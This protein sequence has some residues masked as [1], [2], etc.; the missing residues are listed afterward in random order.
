MLS[1]RGSNRS[2]ALAI[3]LGLAG[4]GAGIVAGFLAGASP[5][6]LGLAVVAVGIVWY[7]F[8]K[9][10]QAVLGLLIL[11]S[12]LDVFSDLQIPA[13]FAVGLDALALLYVIVS[14]LTGRIIRTD[15][16]WWFLV[17]WVLLQGLWL[18]LLHLG[19]LGLDASY[20]LTS[21]REWVRLFSWV[22]VYLLVMQLK[23]RLPPEKVISRLFLALPL[24]IAVA[25]L[26]IPQGSDRIVGTFGTAN[27]FATFLLLFISLVWWNLY[28]TQQQ[29]FW[30]MLLGLL[31]FF[32]VSTKSLFSLMMIAVFVLVL[33]TPRLNVAKL[34]SGVLLLGLVIALFASTEFGQQRLASIAQTPLLNP[35]MDISRAI[36]LSQGDSN[37]FN[38]RLSQWNLLLNAWKQSPIFGYG[39]GLSI[40]VAGNDLLPHNDYIRALVEGGIIGLITFLALFAA[41]FIHLLRLIQQT[42]YESKQRNLCFILLAML[43]S[44]PVGMITENIWSHTTFFFYWWVLLAVASWNWN[45]QQIREDITFK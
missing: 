35:D 20:L 10:E 36:L 13:A 34:I 3:L 24:P 39:L 28:K 22:M 40:P 5:K 7:F 45:E 6:L 30:L 27:T 12:S 42:P 25:L 8:T 2:L 4:V 14:L 21:I 29:W 23:D 32:L 19:A 44:I 18:I 11:R 17:G 33:I 38:W 26:Q 15:G 37:S 16:F 43:S 41:Q 31:C 9:F 1:D